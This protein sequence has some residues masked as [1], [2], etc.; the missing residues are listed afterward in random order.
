MIRKINLAAYHSYIDSDWFDEN[1]Y[2]QLTDPTDFHNVHLF[3]LTV[4]L[5]RVWNR[6]VSSDARFIG[7][8]DWTQIE[9]RVVTHGCEKQVWIGT[10]ELAEWSLLVNE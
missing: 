4:E 1:R 5:L 2:A 9:A 7:P 3:G 10:W 6:D 8:Q